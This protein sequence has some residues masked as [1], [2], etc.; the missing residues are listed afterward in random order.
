M[1]QHGFSASNIMR[2]RCRRQSGA[3]ET[4][5]DWQLSEPCCLDF[6]RLAK[7]VALLLT[8]WCALSSCAAIVRRETICVVVVDAAATDA[9]LCRRRRR[10][11]APRCLFLAA[12]PRART[13]S[14]HPWRPPPSLESTASQST[15]CQFAGVIGGWW[16]CARRCS[17]QQQQQQQY[18]SQRS[19]RDIKCADITIWRLAANALQ[20]WLH[21]W[22]PVI[23]LLSPAD[24]LL[25]HRRWFVCLS[26]CVCDTVCLWPR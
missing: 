17:Q 26:V 9:V 16:T 8:D 15:V 14:P 3:Y 2:L 19:W 22:R 18:L 6:R 24:N 25:F 21:R 23:P 20:V 10:E 7:D 12:A 4:T 11:R 5:V 13:G 1:N